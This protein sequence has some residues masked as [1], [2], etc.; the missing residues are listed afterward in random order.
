MTLIITFTQ[1]GILAV[2]FEVLSLVVRSDVANVSINQTPYL[3]KM[4]SGMCCFD[5]TAMIGIF[6][7]VIGTAGR[8]AGV[9]MSPTRW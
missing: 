3:N 1:L 8:L 7:V 9:G 2:A 6:E 4:L 5:V